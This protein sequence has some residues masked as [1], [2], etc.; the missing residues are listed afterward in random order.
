MTSSG[1]LRQGNSR[2]LFVFMRAPR[3]LVDARI[4]FF[5]RLPASR[6]PRKNVEKIVCAQCCVCQR[7][8]ICGRKKREK[9]LKKVAKKFG[10]SEKRRTFAIPFGNGGTSGAARHAGKPFW[11]ALRSSLKRLI[12]RY[13]RVPITARAGDLGRCTRASTEKIQ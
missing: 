12:G 11:K 10:G 6:I 7:I 9:S 8:G 13:F 2:S 1:R 3:L 4:I 5:R